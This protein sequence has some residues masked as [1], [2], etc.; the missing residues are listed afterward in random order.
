MNCKYSFPGDKR[1]SSLTNGFHQ[2]HQ[3]NTLLKEETGDCNLMDV[4]SNISKSPLRTEKRTEKV[5]RRA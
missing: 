1:L 4:M 3:K 5:N 2:T